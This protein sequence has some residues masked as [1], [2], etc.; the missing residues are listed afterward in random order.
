MD[1]VARHLLVEPERRE[2]LLPPCTLPLDWPA[3]PADASAS[4][5]APPSESHR[6]TPPT[7]INSAD[8][9]PEQ[10][11]CRW[12]LVAPVKPRRTLCGLLAD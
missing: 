9:A 6:G 2:S 5:P 12:R 1:I 4:I 8:R 3:E 11:E 7:S 10:P